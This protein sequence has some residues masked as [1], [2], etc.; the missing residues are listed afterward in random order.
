MV[1]RIAVCLRWSVR[2]TRTAQHVIS[3][4]ESY[5]A[6]AMGRGG[7]PDDQVTVVRTGPDTSTLYR[8]EA[9]PALLRGRDY[10]VHFHGVMGRQD[11]VEVVL[12]TVREFLAIGRTDTFFN[13]MGSGD[14]YPRLRRLAAEWGLDDFVYMPGRVSDQDLF[15]SMSSAVVGLS[16]D[17]PGPLNDVSTMNKTME[18]MAFGLPVLA[19][20]LKETRVSAGDSAEYVRPAT[21]YAYAMALAKLIDDP[22]RRNDMGEIGCAS[23]ARR[24]GLANPAPGLPLGLRA[25]DSRGTDSVTR[26]AQN[27]RV[28]AHAADR[29]PTLQVTAR[30]SGVVG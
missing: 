14:D 9:D 16:P 6:V 13:I 19:F 24:T 20:D 17:A 22:A 29:T 7:V 30:A 2:R 4:N 27:P 15:A 18:Y 28:A 1:S 8:R 10:L 3:T 21:S 12:E 25:A 23:R 11:G 5:K 26:L